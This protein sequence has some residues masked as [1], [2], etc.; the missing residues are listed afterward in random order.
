MG[1]IKIIEMIRD[2][3]MCVYFIGIIDTSLLVVF[4]SYISHHHE[5]SPL[6]CFSNHAMMVL[7]HLMRF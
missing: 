4:Y 6:R 3:S 1:I 7:C 5:S 2:A